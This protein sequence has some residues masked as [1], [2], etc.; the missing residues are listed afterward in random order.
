MGLLGSPKASG[1]QDQAQ[2]TF[3]QSCGPKRALKQAYS[4]PVSEDKWKKH[5]VIGLAQGMDL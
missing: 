5:T 4:G 1:P 3:A 2:I